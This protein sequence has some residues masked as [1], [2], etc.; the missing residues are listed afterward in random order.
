MWRDDMLDFNNKAFFKMKQDPEYA[1][2]VKDLLIEGEEI[3]DAFKSMRDGVVFT[4]KRIIAVNVQG[5]TGSKK[6]YTSLPYK[7]IVAYS[8]ETSGTFDLDSEL[9]IYFSALGK[10]KFEFT[11]RTNIVKISK[12]ISERVF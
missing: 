12:L 1:S 6:D 8:V 2:K 3:I 7:N 10:V 9:E 5:F 11:G 4:S